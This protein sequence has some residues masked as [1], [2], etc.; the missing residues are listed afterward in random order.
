MSKN[1]TECYKWDKYTEIVV[2]CSYEKIRRNYT[3]GDS[4]TYI[5]QTTLSLELE[6]A[7][8]M[9]GSEESTEG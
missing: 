6:I 2:A 8:E 3:K 1:S 7:L 4:K 5:P 9:S